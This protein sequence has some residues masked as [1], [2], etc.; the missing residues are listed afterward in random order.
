[1]NGY[2]AYPLKRGIGWW[3]MIRVCRESHPAP[4]L[5][6][7]DRPKVFN[8]RGEAAE[9]CLRHLVA[10]M[11]GREIRGE[12]FDGRST[13]RDE[14]DRVFFSARQDENKGVAA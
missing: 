11:N 6:K 1:M 4:V 9:E 14:V 10:F 2:A 12:R 7:G 8:S 3:A 5:A 13:Y